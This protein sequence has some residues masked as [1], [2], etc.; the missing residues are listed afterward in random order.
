MSLFKARNNRLSTFWCTA[1]MIKNGKKTVFYYTVILRSWSWVMV[2]VLRKLTRFMVYSNSLKILIN[3][4]SQWK[5]C[6][7]LENGEWEDRC[8]IERRALRMAM[9]RIHGIVFGK[10]SSAL[11]THKWKALW[12]VK[13]S[14]ILLK[15]MRKHWWTSREKISD[16]LER[17][18]A[19]SS[20]GGSAFTET[21]G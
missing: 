12:R 17:F 21:K 16:F 20:K 5:H 2:M 14:C 8:K 19:I 7:W 15:N 9:A 18:V 4:V 10:Y 11:L 3:A 13:I 1:L 6:C